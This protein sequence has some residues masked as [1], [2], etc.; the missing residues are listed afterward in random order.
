MIITL[1]D[2]TRQLQ[3]ITDQSSSL[4][5]RYIQEFLPNASNEGDIC[6][7]RI[8][9]ELEQ[10]PTDYS[11]AGLP[12]IVKAHSFTHTCP[13]RNFKIVTFN[14]SDANWRFALAYKDTKNNVYIVY[15]DKNE[16][17]EPS[18]VADA[19]ADD[20]TILNGT[21][22][23]TDTCGFVW[24]NKSKYCPAA[25]QGLTVGVDGF[26]SLTYDLTLKSDLKSSDDLT[27]SAIVKHSSTYNHFVVCQNAYTQDNNLYS[28]TNSFDGSSAGTAAFLPNIHGRSASGLQMVEATDG[29]IYLSAHNSKSINS[30]VARGQLFTWNGS[31]FGSSLSWS[32]TYC[33][34]PACDRFVRNVD[35]KPIHIFLDDG[36]DYYLHHLEEQLR[37]EFI[38]NQERL[39]WIEFL[40]IHPLLEWLE[41]RYDQKYNRV[42]TYMIS[43]TRSKDNHI[44]CTISSGGSA[45]KKH[46]NIHPQNYSTKI[47]FVGITPNLSEAKEHIKKKYESITS[48]DENSLTIF[49]NKVIRT[50][51]SSTNPNTRS[52]YEIVQLPLDPGSTRQ[53]QV[54]PEFIRLKTYMLKL[55]RAVPNG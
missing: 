51:Q 12:E 47:N 44:T 32:S 46:H 5:G 13:I 53:S 8:I 43:Q 11:K 48:W 55:F 37:T 34:R 4:Q 27:Y 29:T 18:R 14:A 31:S 54:N 36:Y 33:T 20:T 3:E 39:S 24:N 49:Q 30:D 23:G 22:N 42:I 38:H 2:W 35:G 50:I 15:G 16:I 41:L 25:L 26:I 28:V 9:L 40:E 45:T 17:S 52:Y 1:S 10:A 7:N 21:S 19:F 6:T